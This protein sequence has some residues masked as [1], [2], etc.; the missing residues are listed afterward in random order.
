MAKGVLVGARLQAEELDWLDAHAAAHGITTR[1]GALAD[2]LRRAMAGP[3]ASAVLDTLPKA[4]PA[5]S[6]PKAGRSGRAKASAPKVA[7]AV[8]AAGPHTET[9]PPMGA[10]VS[11]VEGLPFGR[12]RPPFG[13]MLKGAGS[14]GRGS[15]GR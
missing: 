2:V 15:R 7:K 10:R 8:K 3:V 4:E 5:P 6:A 14:A 12:E 1:G 9:P 13:S 11:K